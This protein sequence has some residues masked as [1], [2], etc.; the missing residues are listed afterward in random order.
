MGLAGY[1]HGET[2]GAFFAE[3]DAPSG[4]AGV[5]DRNCVMLKGIRRTVWSFPV[6]M[7]ILGTLIYLT[8]PDRTHRPG[9]P[10]AFSQ[11]R[12]LIS[13]RCV[14][15]HS[16]SPADKTFG[17]IPG[18][19][20]FDNPSV[21]S[22]YADKIRIRVVETKTMPVGNKTGVTDEERQLFGAWIAQGAKG[23]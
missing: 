13:R 22:Q 19:I 8:A 14:A 7:G 2:A 1:A 16:M 9:A 20:N 12:D 21:A 15:C 3:G 6:L 4:F 5:G 17:L 10:V 23:E 18:G 11:I